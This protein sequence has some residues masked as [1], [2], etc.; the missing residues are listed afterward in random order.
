MFKIVMPPCWTV[1]AALL[2][3]GAERGLVS[4]LI[5][6]A[7]APPSLRCHLSGVYHGLIA[8]CVAP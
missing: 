3:L 2:W 1:R 7:I 8:D 5:S 4:R 6:V